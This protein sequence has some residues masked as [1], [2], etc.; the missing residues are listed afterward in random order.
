LLAAHTAHG[1]QDGARELVLQILDFLEQPQVWLDSS[2]LRAA[3]V[4]STP[5]SSMP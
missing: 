4:M 5:A 2:K 3:S 1:R